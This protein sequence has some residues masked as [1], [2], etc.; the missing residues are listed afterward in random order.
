MTTNPKAFPLA[1]QNLTTKIL[2]LVQQASHYKQI[3]KGANETLSTMSRN[4]AAERWQLDAISEPNKREVTKFDST[5]RL[6][7][8]LA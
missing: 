2:D 8:Q 6:S 5:P 7:F 3:K 4:P 1:D